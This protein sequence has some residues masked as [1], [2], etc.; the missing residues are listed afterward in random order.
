MK[1]LGHSDPRPTETSVHS[2]GYSSAVSR[3]YLQ[4]LIAEKERAR[5][6]CDPS[7]EEVRWRKISQRTSLGRRALIGARELRRVWSRRTNLAT[8]C[9]VAST[10][11][12]ESR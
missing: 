7:R 8:S 6:S 9:L 3:Q 2:R 12:I 1:R 11:S 5:V 4:V 10:F